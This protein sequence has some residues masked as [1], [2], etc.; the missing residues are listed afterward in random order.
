MGIF[1]PMD[2]V[3]FNDAFTKSFGLDMMHEQIYWN[4]A[5]EIDLSKKLKEETQGTIEKAINVGA[6]TGT[7]GYAMVPL[8]YDQD[9]IDITRKYTPL[10]GMIPKVTNQG[11]I[12][13]YFRLTARGAPTWGTERGA[14]SDS[15]DTRALVQA[16]IKY[17]RI[18][19]TVT[20]VGEVAGQ[21]FYDAMQAEI[22]AKTQSMNEELEDVLVNGDAGTYPL[23]PDG[24]IQM[25]D[26]NQTNM[27]ATEVSLADVKNTVHE[28]Y[29]DKGR[30]NLIITDAFTAGK[31]EQQMMDFTRYTNPT[32]NLGWGLEAM[33]LNTVI[34]RLPILVSQFMPT[35]TG[36]RRILVIDT[37]QVQ[38]RVLQDIMFQRLAKTGDEE[39]FYLKTYRTLINKFPE[40]MGQIYGI[41]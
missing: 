36:S 30:P 1:Q 24:L 28:C 29:M 12:A 25:L 5:K 4:P 14:L 23:E 27:A 7:A 8:A 9:V 35:T 16:T 17:C 15:D 13:N 3:N 11:T 32:A 40:G 37:N 6:T 39:S 21:H 34:G 38:W 2:K 18:R 10:L 41:A 19:G 26:Y 31:L 20:D 33:T 22:A